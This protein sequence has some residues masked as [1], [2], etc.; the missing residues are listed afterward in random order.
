[1]I[2]IY[3]MFCHLLK[4]NKQMRKHNLSEV[5]G[6][7]N[8]ILKQEANGY[9]CLFCNFIFILYV[10]FG[11]PQKFFHI[12]PGY[13]DL[14]TKAVNHIAKIVEFSVNATVEF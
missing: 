8:V 3:G 12:C 6:K 9:I 10:I 7:T 2:N 13:F 5:P 14:T 4:V 11:N 1:M